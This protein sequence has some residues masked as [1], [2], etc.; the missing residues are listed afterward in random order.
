MSQ[1]ALQD[2]HQR[3]SEAID[4]G[5]LIDKHGKHINIYDSAEGLNLLSNVIH[6]NADSIN[7]DYYGCVEVMYKKIF[8]FVP[9]PANKYHVVPSSLHFVSSSMRD[10][11]F[12]GIFK[13]IVNYWMRYA[14]MVDEY[15]VEE[16]DF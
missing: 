2:F 12:Y 3:I 14:V 4:S 16:V 15:R 6:C 13:N 8:G 7:I 10:P 5:Y 1:Q 9:E 11:V